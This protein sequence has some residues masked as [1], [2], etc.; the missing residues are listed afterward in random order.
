MA[1]RLEPG[2][3]NKTTARSAVNTTKEKLSRLPGTSGITD[4]AG[5]RWKVVDEDFDGD[6]SDS[7]AY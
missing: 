3:R 6:S 5:R 2:G 7:D 4:D 1:M